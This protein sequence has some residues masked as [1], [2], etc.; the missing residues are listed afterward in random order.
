MSLLSTVVLMIPWS[1]TTSPN[2]FYSVPIPLLFATRYSSSLSIAIYAPDIN[3]QLPKQAPKKVKPELDEE[4]KAFQDKLRKE[5][6]EREKLA[7]IGEL[8]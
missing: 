1:L 8:F 4:D 5:A 2:P 6:K 3:L 7:L